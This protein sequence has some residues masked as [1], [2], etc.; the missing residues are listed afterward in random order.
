MSFAFV[1]IY[2]EGSKLCSFKGLL[3]DSKTQMFADY[4]G[5]DKTYEILQLIQIFIGFFLTVLP[6]PRIV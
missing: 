4:A 6:G 5:N 1:W 2:S 3:R